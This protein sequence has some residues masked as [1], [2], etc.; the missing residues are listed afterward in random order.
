VRRSQTDKTIQD[1]A[2]LAVLQC[3]FSFTVKVFPAINMVPVREEPLLLTDTEYIT[4]PSPVPL[5]LDVTVNQLVLL[6]ADQLHPRSAVT[7][8]L[9]APPLLGN[10]LDVG[11]IAK[12]QASPAPD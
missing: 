4:A 8:T 12:L 3:G 2:T 7:F 6:I 5:L 9:L 11:E 1:K 10:D